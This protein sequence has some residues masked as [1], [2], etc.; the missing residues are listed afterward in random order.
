MEV[1]IERACLEDANA[2]ITVQNVAFY[3]DFIAYG[4]CPAYN[5]SFNAMRDH[6]ITKIVYKII[7]QDQIIGD[8]IIRPIGEGRYYIRVI[9][10]KPEYQGKGIGKKAMQ[11]IE[12]EITDAKEWELI[13]PFKSYRNHHFYEK[14]GFQKIDQYKHS[15]VLTMF[16]Y[17]K[18]LMSK[19]EVL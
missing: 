16:V 15:D 3:D 7:A 12:S 19:P 1:F 8:I 14:L 18:S 10:I 6:I 13:T 2:L 11:F 5:E 9:S 17:K 4:E